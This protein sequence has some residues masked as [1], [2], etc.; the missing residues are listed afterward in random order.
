MRVGHHKPGAVGPSFKN[1]HRKYPG[2]TLVVQV[3]DVLLHQV[4]GLRIVQETG[5]IV[6]EPVGIALPAGRGINARFRQKGLQR[7]VP[8]GPRFLE[9]RHVR[10]V[11]LQDP[12]H[13][14]IPALHRDPAPVRMQ[15]IVGHDA[16]A[17]AL[18]QSGVIVGLFRNA[19]RNQAQRQDQD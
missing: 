9:S 10:H 3:Q 5:R 2:G 1:S 13:N 8:F 17:R 7:L 15:D 11:V 6:E 12:G 18:R 16:E 4:Y 14:L 19:R